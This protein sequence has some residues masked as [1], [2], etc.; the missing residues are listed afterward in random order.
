M[1]T[2]GDMLDDMVAKLSTTESDM[3]EYTERQK[4]VAARIQLIEERIN[5]LERTVLSQDKII[6]DT[7]G[8][9]TKLD[10]AQNKWKQSMQRNLENC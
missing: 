10:I 4:S 9:T 1:N 5:K 6:S 7:R 2:W 3:S 8:A